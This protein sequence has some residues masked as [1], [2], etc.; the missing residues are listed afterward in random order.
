MSPEQAG[1]SA[2][3]IDTTSDVYSLGVVLYELLVGAL[4]FDAAR[5]RRAGYDEVRRIIREEEVVRPSTRLTRM[6]LEANNVAGRH[7]TDRRTLY[8]ELRGDLDWLTLKAME[9]DRTRRY[10][11]ASEF[12]A[13]VRRYLSD[14]PVIARPPT[15]G[16]RLQK[17][18]K[19]RRGA[20]LAVLS[21]IIALGLGFATSLLLYARARAATARAQQEAYVATIRAADLSLRSGDLEETRRRLEL[22]GAG[23]RGWEWG[24]LASRLDS[25]TR[26]LQAGAAIRQVTFSEGDRLAAIGQGMMWNSWRSLA[27]SGEATSPDRNVGPTDE[28]GVE[29]VVLAVSTDGKLLLADDRVFVRPTVNTVDFKESVRRLYDRQSGSRLRDLGGPTTPVGLPVVAAFSPDGGTVVVA[30]DLIARSPELR[31]WSVT[32]DTSHVLP[33]PPEARAPGILASHS[34][35]IAHILP[36]ERVGQSTCSGGTGS[37]DSDP[38]PRVRASIAR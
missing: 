6:G 15:P 35:L 11:S 2:L 28:P 26:V 29:S 36:T 9:K 14:E 17:L 7:Q 10:A 13:D 33:L 19:R 12:A 16:Y 27:W 3:D 32:A 22:A 5:L 23:L 24:H 1:L 31:Q 8:R 38:R 21:L 20:V 34:D 18:V 4:P 25:S 37:G 30:R